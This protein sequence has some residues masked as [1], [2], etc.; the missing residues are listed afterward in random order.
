MDNCHYCK[1]PPGKCGHDAKSAYRVCGYAYSTCGIHLI[2]EKVGYCNNHKCLIKECNSSRMR[3]YRFCEYH[4][5]SADGCDQE[6]V[7]TYKVIGNQH[8]LQYCAPHSR[9]R[10]SCDIIHCIEPSVLGSYYCIKHKCVS[11]NKY[12][13]CDKHTCLFCGKNNCAC[14]KI[15][16][17]ICN[18]II[19]NGK[20]CCLHKCLRI[21]CDKAVIE[22]NKNFCIEH[23]CTICGYAIDGCV[24]HRF[25]N[26]LH[27]AKYLSAVLPKDICRIICAYSN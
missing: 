26:L 14:D 4:K 16:C 6:Y 18:V 1:S 8:A 24:E 22:K 13:I 7:E 19:L 23:K 5:C 9:D 11:C 3:G 12:Y 10:D 25:Q 27:L 20:V 15:R 21:N 2:S 17:I